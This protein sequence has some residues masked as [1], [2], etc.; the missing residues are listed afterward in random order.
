MN[1]RFVKIAIEG[2]NFYIKGK[3]FTTKEGYRRRVSDIANNERQFLPVIVEE[4]K[5]INK[6][7]INHFPPSIASKE[8]SKTLIINKDIIHFI[9]PLE[10]EE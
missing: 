7:I 4:I 8:N 9:V 3:V 10:N 6:E 5:L 1:G 2:D